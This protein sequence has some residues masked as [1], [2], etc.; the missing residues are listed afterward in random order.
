MG[1][2]CPSEIGLCALLGGRWR[3]PFESGLLLDEDAMWESKGYAF[4]IETFL[5]V[6]EDRIF[7]I[8]KLGTFTPGSQHKVL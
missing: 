6:T 7:E 5:D 4:G 3:C 1:V 8:Q 2:I